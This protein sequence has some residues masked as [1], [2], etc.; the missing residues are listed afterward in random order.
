M[1]VAREL[2]VS[3]QYIGRLY[4]Q[5]MAECVRM[6]G[7]LAGR[8]R[9]LQDARLEALL[10]EHWPNRAN[11]KAAEVILRC[12]DRKARL[13]GLDAPVRLEHGGAV[14]V[15]PESAEARRQRIHAESVAQLRAMTPEQLAVEAAAFLGE[16][17]DVESEAVEVDAE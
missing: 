10:R 5:A 14:E 7:E 4:R 17:Y 12:V 15:L 1:D 2:G 8:E 9:A 11:P 16:S 3:P 6:I 13:Y